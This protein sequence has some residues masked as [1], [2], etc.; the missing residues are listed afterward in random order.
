[1][2]RNLNEIHLSV[3]PPNDEYRLFKTP[4]E[5]A[6]YMLKSDADDTEPKDPRIS[7]NKLLKPSND[8]ITVYQYKSELKQQEHLYVLA[9]L[10]K[11]TITHN[12]KLLKKVVNFKQKFLLNKIKDKWMNEA[13]HFNK[14]A[15]FYYYNHI[16]ELNDLISEDMKAYLIEKWRTIERSHFQDYTFQIVTVI[17]QAKVSSQLTNISIEHVDDLSKDFN[18]E[19]YEI[20]ENFFPDFSPFSIESLKQRQ[21]IKL[22]IGVE[23]CIEYDCKIPLNILTKLFTSSTECS[24]MFENVSNESTGRIATN[25]HSFEALPSRTVD[26]DSALCEIVKTAIINEIE[27]HNIEKCIKMIDR[28]EGEFKSQKINDLMSKIFQSYKKK[29]GINVT[30]NLWKIEKDSRT[31]SI[32]LSDESFYMKGD[33]MMNISVKLEY[34][35]NFGA[36]TMTKSELLAEYLALK[37]K[38]NSSTLRYR[39]DAKS[40]TIL[41]IT[42]INIEE[43]E[44]ELKRL[45]NYDPNESIDILLNTLY[46]INKLPPSDYLIE[47]RNENDCY[48]LKIFKATDEPNRKVEEEFK[49]CANFTRKFIPI[50]HTHVTH[51]NINHNIAPACFSHYSSKVSYLIKTPIV[52]EETNKVKKINN[53]KNKIRCSKRIKK[54]STAKIQK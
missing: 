40:C 38:K 25:F 11:K 51:V 17:I 43:V 45:Y 23:E 21:K 6:T 28:V 3:I 53:N 47:A 37:L 39:V 29:A 33:I 32:L 20:S 13:S 5:T 9:N 8:L 54:K 4:E 18:K 36:E 22:N 48:K 49:I 16:N 24:L 41:S 7:L 50:D 52:K 10:S 30:T 15:E 34:Q 14:S 46:C 12:P 31:C 27:W 44:E 2:A 26:I 1:L 19:L 42:L 35:T